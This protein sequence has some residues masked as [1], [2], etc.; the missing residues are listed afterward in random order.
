MDFNAKRTGDDD[1][2]GIII[3]GSEE[4]P[5][6]RLQSEV[7]KEPEIKVSPSKFKGMLILFIQFCTSCREFII[8]LSASIC[9]LFVLRA[10][11]LD[12]TLKKNNYGI[13]NLLCHNSASN[14]QS[15]NQYK[16]LPFSVFLERIQ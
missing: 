2:L 12:N 10:N 8:V 1:D 3:V 4:L 11:L 13:N 15:Q 9:T 16:S 6:L 14:Q 7:E 5:Y